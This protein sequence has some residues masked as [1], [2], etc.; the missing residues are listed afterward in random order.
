MG[1]LVYTFERLKE[2]GSQRAIMFLAGIFQI[3]DVQLNNWLGVATMV[4]GVLAVFTPEGI[5]A[6]K[7]EGFSK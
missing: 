6:T 4:M 5:P 7:I 1:K 2:P 3:P